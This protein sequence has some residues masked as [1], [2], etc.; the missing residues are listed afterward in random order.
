MMVLL[1]LFN[2]CSRQSQNYVT[3][4]GT[5]QGTT[6]NIIYEHSD[7][8]NLKSEIDSI[9]LQF[10]KSMSVWDSTS[11]ISKVNNNDS[12]VILD[13]YFIDVFNKAMEVSAVTDGKFDI[14]IAPLVNAFGFGP[15]KRTAIDSALVDSLIQFVGYK[16]INIVN[17]K[18]VKDNPNITID[19]NALAQG[20][21]VDII[22]EFL[23]SKG[24]K[25]FLVEIGGEVRTVGE[26]SSGNAWN[27]GVDKPVEDAD[28][29]DRQLQVILKIS[30]LAIAT[31]GNYRK[32]YEENGIK[33]SHS[34]DPTTG[35]P[36]RSNLLSASILAKDCMTADA[37]ATACMIV[38]LEKSKQLLAANPNLEG[39]LIFVN[40]KG[41]FEVY[42][43]K[44]V[45]DLIVEIK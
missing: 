15:S 25:N 13:S 28:I 27:V 17:N 33:F 37:Y 14:T 1:V 40:E 6:Y 36:I 31:S 16:K 3:L 5:A 22:C 41:E 29:V 32:F 23:S 44:G 39:Y 21:S 26:N 10:D 34:F 42:Y 20:K 30:N 18:I 2:S 35:Y 9:L 19:C 38:G 45:E 8:L 12:S 43:T 7:K 24:C 4:F 11:V